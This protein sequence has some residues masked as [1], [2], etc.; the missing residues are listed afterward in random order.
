[1]K[2]TANTTNTVNA[3]GQIPGYQPATTPALNPPAAAVKQ[4]R[5]VPVKVNATGTAPVKSTLSPAGIFTG[6]ADTTPKSNRYS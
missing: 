6:T 3:A 2:N 1:M 5:T 4:N